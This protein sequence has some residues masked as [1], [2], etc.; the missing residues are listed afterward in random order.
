V[1]DIGLTDEA[2]V[3]R[4]MQSEWYEYDKTS[5]RSCAMFRV[6]DEHFA[7]TDH[8]DI[9]EI[10][11]I[12]K[13]NGIVVLKTR[14]RRSFFAEKLLPDAKQFFIVRKTRPPPAHAPA[15]CVELAAKLTPKGL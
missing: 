1:A 8:R 4:K 9:L 12:D 7:F 5:R 15:W 13:L 2:G 10:Q 11:M 3:A 14:R 6:Q